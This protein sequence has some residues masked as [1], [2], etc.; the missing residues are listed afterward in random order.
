A[1]PVT[2]DKKR[3]IRAYFW[4]YTSQHLL[5]IQDKDGDENWH[6]YR[7]DLKAGETTD[8]TPIQG[9]NA[10]IDGVSH[11]HPN[12]VLVGLNDRDAKFHD[13]YRVNLVTGAKELVQKNEE[14]AG[15]LTDDDFKVRFAQ[16][17]TP[18]G[19]AAMYKPDGKGGWTDFVKI[20]MADTLTTRAVD[21]DKS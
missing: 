1:K 15:F 9:V 5:Y 12:E 3:G 16:K 20:P 7:V 11:K 13:L 18:D 8:L 2:Q 17:Y 19:G 4:A 14:F 21:F 6:V 10:Q